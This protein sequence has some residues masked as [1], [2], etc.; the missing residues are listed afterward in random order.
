[1]VDFFTFLKGMLIG[2]SI[3]APVGPIGILCI[4]RTIAYGRVVGLF[5][6]L[7]AATA[8]ALYSIF[9]VFGLTIVTNFLIGQQFW[10]Q[11]VGGGFLCY[12]G[13]KT[14]MS[15][16]SVQ[17]AKAQGT[18]IWSAYI[19]VFFLTITNPMTI[20]SFIGIFAGLGFSNSQSNIISSSLLVL[21]VF[22]GS[23]FW[24]LLLSFVVSLVKERIEYKILS[25]I[26]R[27][28]G[29]IILLFGIASLISSLQ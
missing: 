29:L 1:M 19:S 17:S 13:V 26:N 14:M 28:S 21:G 11:T 5:T 10:L 3:A 16:A 8:D 23:A 20:L 18:K 6:G 7:G 9:A 12:L 15:K 25:V 4:R 22:L 27:I 24:W 2:F